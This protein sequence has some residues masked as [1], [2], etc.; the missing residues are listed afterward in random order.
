[1]TGTFVARTGSS[2]TWETLF[3]GYRYDSESGLYQVRYRY[4]H[5]KLGRW[6]TRDPLGEK[7]AINLYGYVQNNVLN[8]SDWAGLDRHHNDSPVNPTAPVIPN[9]RN[10]PPIPVNTEGFWGALWDEFTDPEGYTDCYAKCM[11]LGTSAHA[12]SELGGATYI[13]KKWY[14]WKYPKWFKAGGKY[15]RKL[16]PKLAEKFGACL[17]PLA[18]KDAWD[19]YHECKDRQ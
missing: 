3:D 14:S 1:M 6:I 5:P 17:A 18:I 19:C 16:V 4:L 11:L 12:G 8:D 9:P 7:V 2:Y 10:R 13:A 15:S